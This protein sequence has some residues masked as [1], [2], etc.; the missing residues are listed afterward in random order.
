MQRF[1]KFA[2]VGGVA[3]LFQYLILVF[4]VELFYLDPVFSSSFGFL[5][6]C[7]LNYLLNYKFT[8]FSNKKHSEA[9][10]K[11]T[12]IAGFGLVLNTL[13]MFVFVNYLEIV[14]F[15][16]QVLSTT[17]VLFWNYYGNSIWTFA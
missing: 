9:F 13:S 10:L 11:F 15:F 7:V 14:Y 1:L 8:F 2:L 4:L 12:L 16:S 17:I 3:T 6:S 5:C